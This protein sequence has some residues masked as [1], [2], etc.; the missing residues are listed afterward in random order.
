MNLIKESFSQYRGLTRSVYVIF[1]ARIVTNMG[2]FIWPMLTLILSGKLGY[3][4]SA[5]AF[6]SVGVMLLFMPAQIIGGKIADHFNRKKVIVIFDVCSVTLFIICGFLTPGT[7]MMILFILAGLFATMEGPAFEA[8][9]ADSTKPAERE[10]VYS[11][12]YLGYNLGFMFGV[13]VG[14]M[15][16]ENYLNLAFIFDGLTTLSSTI[17]IVTMVKVINVHDLKEEER[18]DYEDSIHK[19]DTVFSILKDR[20]SIM[21]M[22]VS[23]VLGAFIYGQWSFALPL[24]LEALFVVRGARYY[25]FLGGFNGAIVVIFTPIMTRLLRKFTEL[26]KMIIGTA[27]YS[28]SFLIIIG[29]PM[30]WVFFVMIF[31]FTLGEILNSIGVSP[32]ISRRVP[33]SHRGRISS[34]MGISHMFGGIIGQLV[35]G[36]LI[37]YESFSVAFGVLAIV[38]VI[39]VILMGINYGVD[40]KRFPRLYQVKRRLEEETQES[41]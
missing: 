32:F 8:L 16:F 17:M 21:V 11:L 24:H 30:Y 10:K 41:Q 22:L 27:L 18:N 9:I 19:S 7:P 35:V 39:A 1:F 38:G 6:I 13:V 2:A 34:Y 12:S 26:P 5:I 23:A 33:A 15:L 37:D 25:G 20:K 14:G 3:S 29:Q 31:A 28:F 40:K 36:L 4:P